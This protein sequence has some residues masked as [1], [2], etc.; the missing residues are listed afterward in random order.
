MRRT[1]E[2]RQQLALFLEPA[3][4]A[5]GDVAFEA[6]RREGSSLTLAEALGLVTSLT[7]SARTEREALD[8]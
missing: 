3:R 7:A 6:A 1:P 4:V 2:D 5:L 8:R